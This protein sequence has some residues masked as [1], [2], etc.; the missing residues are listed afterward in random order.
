VQGGPPA[1]TGVSLGSATAHTAL[2]AA[3]AGVI[4]TI[5][6]VPLAMLSVRH[7]GKLA[8]LLERST[9]LVLAMPGLVTALALSYVVERYAGGFLYQSPWLLTLAY[10]TLFF[11]LALVAVRASAVRAPAR[12]EEVGRSLGRGR[13]AVLARITLPLLAPGLAAGF[14]LVFLSV[15]TELTATLILIPTGVQTLSTQFWAYQQNLSYAQAAPF[16][17]LMMGIAVVPSLIL[18]LWF[19]RDLA[20]AQPS[21]TV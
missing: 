12:L 20:R 10:A 1:L 2:Y 5:A 6:A 21:Q 3:G 16:A 8:H 7:P 4:A 11:P 14:S 13:L 18:G 19:D 15:V 17:L 9:L